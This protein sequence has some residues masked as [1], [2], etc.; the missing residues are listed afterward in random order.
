MFGLGLMAAGAMHWSLFYWSPLPA[1]DEAPRLVMVNF[2]ISP[3]CWRAKKQLEDAGV[4]TSHCV[5][6]H[7]L[8]AHV[9]PLISDPTVPVQVWINPEWGPPLKPATDINGST[10]TIGVGN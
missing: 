8:V 3:Y 5:Y 10:A 2:E 6:S 9:A 7:Y 4:K 1:E